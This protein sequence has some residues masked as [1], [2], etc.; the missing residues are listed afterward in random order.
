MLLDGAK[1][2]WKENS[3]KTIIL[4]TATKENQRQ[5]L[6]EQPRAQLVPA[7]C[8]GGP[9]SSGDEV[10]VGLQHSCHCT[11][12][13]SLWLFLPTPT[14]NFLQSQFRQKP[15]FVS[16]IPHPIDL[17]KG[18]VCAVSRTPR[19]SFYSSQ[20][21]QV[22]AFSRSPTCCLAYLALPSPSSRNKRAAL[23]VQCSNP[24][25]TIKEPPKTPCSS[26]VVA[27]EV[28]RQCLRHRIQAHGKSSLF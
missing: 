11:D 13:A 4:G 5:S 7:G 17:P 18:S 6:H 21:L 22:C 27:S 19:Q 20:R 16:L 8:L 9:R 14:E 15:W 26:E 28:S 25:F 2:F 23:R 10:S 12:A 1:A 3:F 24:A